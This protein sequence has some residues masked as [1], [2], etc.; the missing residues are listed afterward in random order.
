VKRSESGSE[1]V[2]RPKARNGGKACEAQ[3]IDMALVVGEPTLDVEGAEPRLGGKAQG[4]A[5]LPAA[6]VPPYTVIPASLERL[7]V[8]EIARIRNWIREAA[9]RSI[10][11]LIIR[12]SVVGEGLQER[13]LYESKTCEADP[14]QVLSLV[15][16]MRSTG[17]RDLAL[18]LQD[19][20]TPQ[21]SGHLSNERRVTRRR[22][23][24]ACEYDPASLV[25]SPPS[26]LRVRASVREAFD[27]QP[28]KCTSQAELEGALREV[29]SFALDQ[30]DRR[31]HF[32]WVWDGQILWV[33]QVDGEEETISSP[34]GSEWVPTPQP[35]IAPVLTVFVPESNASRPWSKTECVREFRE[36]GL[37][38][39]QVFI[40]EDAD[41]LAMLGRGEI[42][43][44]VAADIE[45]LLRVP[46]VIRTDIA[47]EEGFERVMLPRTTTM[48]SAEEVK[49]FLVR[50]AQGFV[51]GGL[52]PNQ[53]CFLAHAFIVSRA[54][55]FAY[56][57]PRTPRVRIDATWG[58]PDSL[59]YYPH[60]SF[61]VN[62]GRRGFSVQRRLRCKS[63]YL[64]VNESGEWY[65]KKAGRRW[66]WK[67]ALGEE[68]LRIIASASRRL[69]DHLGKPVGVMFF[70]GN[71]PDDVYPQCLPWYF[72]TADIPEHF[73]HDNTEAMFASAGEIVADDED[74]EAVEH[75]AKA[76]AL[77]PKPS[78]RLRPSREHLRDSTFAARVARIAA[79]FGIA[80]ELEGSLLSHAYYVLNR[81]GV[82]VRCVE[83]FTP[84]RT[85]H[86][87]GKLVRDKV[88]DEITLKGERVVAKRVRPEDLLRALKDKAIEES[89]EVF[90]AE[91]LETT[92]QE[93][94]DLFEVIRSITGVLGF[95]MEDIQRVADLKLATRGGFTEGW[96]LEETEQLPLLAP[97]PL[98]GTPAY[99]V[100]ESTAWLPPIIA[101]ESSALAP[102]VQFTRY[103]RRPRLIRFGAG[104]TSQFLPPFS[105]LGER[106]VLRIQPEDRQVVVEIGPS[107][108]AVTIEGG[109]D[110]TTPPP[111]QLDLFA[112]PSL[113]FTDVER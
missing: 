66:D 82:R 87:F 45:A 13:G 88:P 67:E 110:W 94:G 53:F 15:E 39:P 37:P 54:G 102:P 96:I 38:S 77:P 44:A 6:W 75:L 97:S 42:S 27:E 18:I 34:P 105:P 104:V 51:A 71:A 103:P 58:I 31:L 26:T 41:S 33:V 23:D 16:E 69:A 32:E 5:L 25:H 73:T 83:P 17:G 40:L 93:L 36:C 74:L 106:V 68:D 22:D 30:F 55:A 49:E 72:T 99:S 109:R 20:K 112:P 14:T 101:H 50:T 7:D 21:A 46:T 61:E 56:S 1:A 12:S 28:I 8:G 60:D 52:A 111:Q 4:L 113:G 11:R 65:P 59:L 76:A 70:V 80:V 35:T 63:E 2:G 48:T 10:S 3:D 107:G 29:A 64:D 78:I 84:E 24:W 47:A 85:E 90:Y 81:A 86:K 79:R 62:I 9:E 92:L 108:L 98:E 89:A 19:F 95:T 43:M 100:S 91:D 57:R